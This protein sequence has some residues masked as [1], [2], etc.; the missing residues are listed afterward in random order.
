MKV[1]T[2]VENREI[3]ALEDAKCPITLRM[4]LTHTAGVGCGP[5]YGAQYKP[6]KKELS[7]EKS[8]KRYAECALDFQP[9]T[10]QS[11]SPVWGLDIIAHL[12]EKT[13]DMPYE[14][15]IKKFIFDPLGMTDTT[16]LP[17]DEQLPRC[18]DLV[19]QTDKGLIK[20]RLPS[21]VGFLDFE[22]G[23]ASGGAGL[24]STLSDYGNFA[25]ML[26]NGGKLDGAR[27]LSEESVRLMSTAQLPQ[28]LEGVT[29]YLNWGLGTMVYPKYDKTIQPLPKGTFKFSGFFGTHSWV[30][31]QNDITCVYMMNISN[32]GDI[33]DSSGKEFEKDVMSGI[34]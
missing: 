9:G 25:R 6:M 26:L 23:F 15:Y 8:V 30:D 27:I 28:N 31:R 5:S 24:F 19:T 4:L 16:Y 1:A 29:E 14:E 3:L 34:I 7:L 20:H 22:E 17:T 13:A 11:Y 12:I 18:V 33:S 21:K 10:M 2:K 32:G